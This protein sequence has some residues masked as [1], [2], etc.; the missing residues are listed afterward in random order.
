MSTGHGD[1]LSVV[2]ATPA[3]LPAEDLKLEKNVRQEVNPSKVFRKLDA[4]LLPL[5]TLLYLLSFL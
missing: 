2:D 5:V 3:A 1:K 4:R